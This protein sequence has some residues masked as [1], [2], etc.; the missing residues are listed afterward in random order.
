MR[1]MPVTVL[2]FGMMGRSRNVAYADVTKYYGDSPINPYIAQGFVLP[3]E[4]DAAR[5]L[6]WNVNLDLMDAVRNDKSEYV[7]IC[8][9]NAL[10]YSV[11]LAAIEAKKHV[12]CEKP[13]AI[14]LNEAREMK[15]AAEAC[16]G[17]LNSVNFIYRRCPANVYARQIAQ[18]KQF[19]E[20]LEARS[21][22]NQSWGGPGAGFGWR[23]D[24][25]AGG[26]TLGDLGSHAIDML[27]FITGMLPSEVSAT[28][29]THV[30]ERMGTIT[31]EDGSTERGPVRSYVDDGTRFVYN[32][33]NGGIGS[34]ECTRNAWG[35]ENTQGYELYFENGAIRWCYDDV[36]YLDVYDPSIRGRGW[37]RVLCNQGGFAYC[38]FAG[39]HMDGYRD[40]TVSACYENMRAIEGMK[41]IAPIATFADAYEVER[42]I[43]AVRRSNR[44]RRWVKLDE[45]K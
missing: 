25:K 22:Y 12:F 21:Y 8:L 4:A 2:G 20:L 39:G 27:H 13:L 43:E 28:Q 1:D 16:P 35:T 18:E 44:E 41:P 24:E 40:F 15:E 10:H 29:V 45:V 26:G 36:N 33:P 6:G 14:S 32:L 38:H 9:P 30:K 17:L 31:K 19:G 3:N 7:D 11:A 34:F 23:F 37:R 42:V 5:K